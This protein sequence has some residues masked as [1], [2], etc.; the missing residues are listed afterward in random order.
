M[1]TNR[2]HFFLTSFFLV[3]LMTGSAWSYQYRWQTLATVPALKRTNF[4]LT[5]FQSKLW[6]IGGFPVGVSAPPI[7]GL[8]HSSDGISWQAASLPPALGDRGQHATFV[9]QGALYVIGGVTQ[10]G[11]VLSDVWRST[12]GLSWNQVQSSAAFGAR[13][14]HAAAVLNGAIWLIGGMNANQDPLYRRPGIEWA[15]CRCLGE[16]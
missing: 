8:L 14:G 12:D 2:L 13:Q 9:F 10:A 16:L 4:T 15:L 7:P 11:G 5:E 3:L 1:K 6:V